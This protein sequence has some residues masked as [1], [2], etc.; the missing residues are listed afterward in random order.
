MRTTLAES[1]VRAKTIRE[2]EA[3]LSEMEARY[4]DR[5]RAQVRSVAFFLFP[6]PEKTD[7]GGS[8]QALEAEELM[9]AKLDVLTRFE[10]EREAI[11]YA[12]SDSDTEEG[13][14]SEEEEEGASQDLE[15]EGDQESEEDEEEEEEQV[16][17]MLVGETSLAD[18]DSSM[19]RSFSITVGTS[20]HAF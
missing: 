19:V 12:S 5:L 11:A 1:R 8:V 18:A 16:E 3:K 20:R 15:Q 6:K 17:E 14:S 4:E 10:Q 2:Y 13:F 9:N 7:F